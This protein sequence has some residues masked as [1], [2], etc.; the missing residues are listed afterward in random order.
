VAAALCID[1]NGPTGSSVQVLARGAFGHAVAKYAGRFF[2]ALE[3]SDLANAQALSCLPAAGLVVVA[4][5]RIEQRSCNWLD[6][7][8]S[9]ALCGFVPVS[10]E[11]KIL[12]VGPVVVPGAGP[13]WNCWRARLGQHDPWDGRKRALEAYYDETSAAPRGWLDPFALIAAARVFEI[14]CEAEGLA[15]AAGD[16]WEMD[17]FTRA[18]GLRRVMGIHACARCGLAGEEQARNTSALAQALKHLWS[19]DAQSGRKRAHH[20]N[21]G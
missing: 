17:M 4:S 14:A 7:R 12:R 3:V 5:P 10:M 11:G 2:P 20:G 21:P 9:G 6:Q 18:T 1:R 8:C 16:V 15:S 19:E 13:C